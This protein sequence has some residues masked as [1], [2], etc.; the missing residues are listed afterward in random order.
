LV[1]FSEWIEREFRSQWEY[2]GKTLK[3][4]EPSNAKATES[5]QLSKQWNGYLDKA[6]D[7]F[8]KD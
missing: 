4:R 6:Q 3:N 2:F 1:L 7:Y 5:L 8:R